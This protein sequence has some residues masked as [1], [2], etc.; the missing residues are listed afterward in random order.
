MID[1]FLAHGSNNQP[2]SN[3]KELEEKIKQVVSELKGTADLPQ[4]HQL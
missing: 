2:C 4:Y 3:L 1:E